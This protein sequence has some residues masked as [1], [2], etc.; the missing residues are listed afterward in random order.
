[1]KVFG[2]EITKEQLERGIARMT[3]D[4]G[5][6]DIAGALARAGVPTAKWIADRAADRL[7]QAE[8]KA[9]RI[10]AINNRTWRKY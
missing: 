2:C 9:G 1:M 10:Y 6:N 7:L 8:R 4:F 5:K 3:G